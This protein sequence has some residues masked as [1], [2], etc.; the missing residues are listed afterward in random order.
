MLGWIC[1]FLTGLSCINLFFSIV[2][3]ASM[4]LVKLASLFFKF[5]CWNTFFIRYY[6]TRPNG[7]RCCSVH[8]KFCVRHCWLF[9]C[10]TL[11]LLQVP[12]E[13]A[14]AVRE[15]PGPPSQPPRHGCVLGRVC[16]QARRSSSP[17]ERSSAPLLVPA[18]ST[19]CRGCLSLSA[20]SHGGD[21]L[22]RCNVLY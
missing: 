4:P 22:L 7:V 16:A 18:L 10:I 13:S 5:N 6:R 11:L 2:V 15:V 19:R 20:S 17:T 21:R 12:R 8:T 3:L 1:V 14:S 9:A